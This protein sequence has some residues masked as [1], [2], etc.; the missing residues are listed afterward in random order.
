MRSL[1][2]AFTRIHLHP[3]ISGSRVT[4]RSTLRHGCPL[5]GLPIVLYGLTRSDYANTTT[6]TCL[7]THNTA[8]GFGVKGERKNTGHCKG[9]LEPARLH[10]F[11]P[12]GEPTGAE[13]HLQTRTFRVIISLIFTL[14]KPESPTAGLGSSQT[15]T[16]VANETKGSRS[17]GSGCYPFIGPARP[18]DGIGF[19][20]SRH[21]TS[22]RNKEGY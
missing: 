22:S 12:S 3:D 8:H 1:L 18:L 7:G 4:S 19:V 11:F 13:E 21:K 16:P 20:T 5:L 14:D 2:G 9:D 10:S 15:E 17:Q 6:E